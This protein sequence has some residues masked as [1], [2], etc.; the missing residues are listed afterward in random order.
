MVFTIDDIELVRCETLCT[1]KDPHFLG[2][3]ILTNGKKKIISE[4]IFDYINFNQNFGTF[5][6][7]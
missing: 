3:F 6:I 1:D 2:F 5:T 7:F 4:S